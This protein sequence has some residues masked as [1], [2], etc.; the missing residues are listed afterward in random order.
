MKGLI[1]LL[2][3]ISCSHTPNIDPIIPPNPTKPNGEKFCI[4]GDGGTGESKQYEVAGALATEGCTRVL[5]VGDIIYQYG[6][7]SIED[8]AFQK[9]FY[10]PYKALIEN[11]QV[12]FYMSMGNHDWYLLGSADPWLKINETYH[13][14]FYPS[15][16]YAYAFE[17]GACIVQFEVYKYSKWAEIRD[18]YSKLKASDFFSKCQLVIGFSHYPYKSSGEHGDPSNSE[19][20]YLEFMGVGKDFDYYVAGH[21]HQLSDEGMYKETRLLISGAA[22]KLRELAKKPGIW[23]ASEYGYL[24]INFEKEIGA[25]FYFVAVKNGQKTIVHSGKI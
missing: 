7:T 10:L 8:E 5:Y 3:L 25:N 20:T 16:G 4:I 12:P 18:W 17:S 11:Q 23:G 24:V 13:N 14:I 21:D 19:K 2:L 15:Y 6:I 22:G 1:I 9:K